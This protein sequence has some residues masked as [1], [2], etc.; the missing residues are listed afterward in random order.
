MLINVISVN[1]EKTLSSTPQQ[2]L[3]VAKKAREQRILSVCNQSKL[4]GLNIRFWEGATSE[5][6]SFS[7]ISMSHKM[8]VADAKNRGLPNVCIAEDDFLLSANGAWEYFLSNIPE[9]YD[10]FLSGIYAGQIENGRITNGFSGL[11]LYIVN[12]R[13]YDFY[14]SLNHLD[15][16]DRNLGN[17]A[18]E[19]K[20]IVIEPFIAKQMSEGYSDNHRRPVSHEEYLKE[21]KFFEG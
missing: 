4:H 18:F 12:S 15:H 9:D 7:N 17:Y 13:F 10:L 11:T 1:P 2:Y 3:E 21:M 20:Y 16:T 19:K 14:L 6:F 8:I 5:K